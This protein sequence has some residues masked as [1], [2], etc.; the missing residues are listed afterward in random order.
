MLIRD[1]LYLSFSSMARHKTRFTLTTLGVLFACLTLAASLSIGQGVQTYLALLTQRSGMLRKIHLFPNWEIVPAQ[2]KGEPVKVEGDFSPE[3]NARLS[4]LLELEQNNRNGKRVFHGLTRENIKKIQA[5]PGVD[6]V[7][8]LAD[9]TVTAKWNQNTRDVHC[10]AAQAQS[11]ELRPRLVGGRLFES[12]QEKGVLVSEVCLYRLGF[13][14][15]TDFSACLGQS[16]RLEIARSKT[17]PGLFVSLLKADGS[18]PNPQE[19]KILALINEKLASGNLEDWIGQPGAKLLQSAT[20][21]SKSPPPLLVREFPIVGI[22]RVPTQSEENGPWNPLGAYRELVLPCDNAADL[23]WELPGKSTQGLNEAIVVARTV[24]DVEPL[25]KTLKAAGFRAQGMVEHIQRQKLLYLMIFAGM[26]CVACVAVGV[27][28]LGITNTLF[29][30][31]LERTR[32]IGILKALG[33]S[34]GLILGLFLVEGAWIGL[35]GGLG[36]LALTW[37]GSFPGDAWIR[38]M[39]FR[40]LR[41]DITDSLFVF[42][43]WLI[44]G[45]PLFSVVATLLAGWGPSVRAASVDPVVALR[46]D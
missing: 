26:T 33:A 18:G 45:V 17:N 36:G 3:R 30:S 6:Q 22:L 29:M 34:R 43:W 39:V 11:E 16:L 20:D 28:A 41:V 8:P 21:K 37:I 2:A 10:G 24:E 40:E 9:F 23:F 5:M 31:V 7:I 44:L 27:A 19:Q 35:I 13:K 42:P 25:I 38:G 15:D 14:T 46:H 1:L 12:N 32:E 4:T